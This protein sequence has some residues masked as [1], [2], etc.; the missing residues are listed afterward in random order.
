[1]NTKVFG[2]NEVIFREGEFGNTFYEIKEGTEDELTITL[3]KD[4][5]QNKV[6]FT[7]GYNEGKK[8]GYGAKN[9]F[10]KDDEGTWVWVS[11]LKEGGE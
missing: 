8:R 10:S 7:N 2:K 4:S 3:V 9:S 11:D 5:T 6:S 1:M